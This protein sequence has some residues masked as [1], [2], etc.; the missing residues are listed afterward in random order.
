M[1]NLTRAEKNIIK[2]L[3]ANY[4]NGQSIRL[5]EILLKVYPIEY[6]EP[7]KKDDYF[8][9]NTINLCYDSSHITDNNILEAV[10]LF[11]LLIRKNYLVT[12]TFIDCDIIGK[13]C[14]E[15]RLATN[16]YRTVNLMNYY[17]YDLWTLLCS[18]Y[19]VTNSLVDFAEDYKTGEQ[20]RH[21]AEMKIALKSVKWSKRA[22][23]IAL[24]TLFLSVVFDIKQMCSSQKIDASQISTI[25]KT[26]IKNNLVKEPLTVE[27][28]DTI[29]TKP[30]SV[31]EQTTSSHQLLSIPSK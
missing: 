13:K 11:D 31:N 7:G 28:K 3:L 25:E 26:A 19:Y 12:K 5:G 17:D 6:I 29:L 4:S 24:I 14:R 21:E 15:M 10:N 18:H 16:H 23:V 2:E 30:V 1:R 22:A 9:K 8:Y 27:I 20:R